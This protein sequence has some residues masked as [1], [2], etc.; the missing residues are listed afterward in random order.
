M[1]E[2]VPVYA[3]LLFLVTLRRLSPFLPIVPNQFA[4]GVPNERWAKFL[5]QLVY[6]HGCNK[7]VLAR[8]VCPE[9]EMIIPAP[10]M[11]APSSYSG[12]ELIPSGFQSLTTCLP[13]VND[14]F[15]VWPCTS[16]GTMTEVS[17]E[18]DARK[19]EDCFSHEYSL[20]PGSPIR[21]TTRWSLHP[22]TI[23]GQHEFLTLQ[24]PES[25]QLRLG[26]FPNLM[27]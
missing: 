17:Q 19:I 8:L 6:R 22:A 23:T 21:K 1:R 20:G 12:I 11:P 13:N 26:S 5:V 27:D 10:A 25:F 24:N 7:E 14:L 15:R 18:I 2:K 4:L 9:T 16:G 3:Q